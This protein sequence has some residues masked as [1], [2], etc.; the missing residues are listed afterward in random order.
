MTAELTQLLQRMQ[1]YDGT[2]LIAVITV[3][4]LLIDSASRSDIDAT[5]VAAAT[6][7]ALLMARALG[8]ELGRGEPNLI[9]I[10]YQGGLLLLQP[11]DED[12]GLVMLAPRE[13]NLGRLRLVMRKY[14]QELVRATT[15]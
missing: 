15:V 8:G 5:A 2:D 9:T 12:L 3:D 11:L 6:C 4:G 1:A 14:A 7:N 10:E 13:T